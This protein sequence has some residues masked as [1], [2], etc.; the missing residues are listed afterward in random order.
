MQI[1][2]IALFYQELSCKIDLYILS[3]LELIT[4]RIFLLCIA[5]LLSVGTGILAA[6]ALFGK[7]SPFIYVLLSSGISILLIFA[8][9]HMIYLYLSK[10]QNK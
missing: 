6:C 10:K 9:F 8:L 5:V 3:H 4:L 1:Y 2:R 7:I